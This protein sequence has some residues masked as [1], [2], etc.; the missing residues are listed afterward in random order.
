MLEL[1][2][3][4]LLQG[5]LQEWVRVCNLEFAEGSSSRSVWDQTTNG[6]AGPNPSLEDPDEQRIHALVGPLK[7]RAGSMVGSAL[8]FFEKT[9]T[10]VL[11]FPAQGQSDIVR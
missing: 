8:H 6:T 7:C 1:G 3:P 11:C 9:L 10:P 4:G 5:R 2:D